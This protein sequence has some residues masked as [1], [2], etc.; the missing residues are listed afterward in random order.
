MYGTLN[1]VNT[2]SFSQSEFLIEV[3]ARTAESVEALSAKGL[4]DV[5]LK[6]RRD[7]AE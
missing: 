5:T 3:E 6:A 4:S 7:R 1:Y 2:K